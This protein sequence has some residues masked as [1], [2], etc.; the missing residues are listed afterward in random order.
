MPQLHAAYCIPE[1]LEHLPPSTAPI[2]R[3]LL[4]SLAH[5]ELESNR[6]LQD[7]G[8][9]QSDA[10]QT[11][12]LLAV[13]MNLISRGLPTRAPLALSDAVL[14]A[15]WPGTFDPHDDELRGVGFD[16]GAVSPAFVRLL[17][18]ALHVVEPRM[19]AEQFRA[20]TKKYGAVQLDSGAERTFLNDIVAGNVE[21]G[22]G[23]AQVMLPQ[24]PL[25][26]LLQ[27]GIDDNGDID[28][29]RRS[30][31][32]NPSF[33]QHVD[34]AMPLPYAWPDTGNAPRGLVM[35][36]DGPH[37]KEKGQRI[38]DAARDKAAHE[39]RWRTD[40]LPVEEMASPDAFLHNLLDLARNHPYCK[41]LR[42][43]CK[44][45]LHASD[46]GRRAEQL[47]LTPIL[48]ARIHRALLEALTHGILK[49]DEKT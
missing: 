36:V 21:M 29:P 44:Q 23:L 46:D 31:D 40:R 22:L 7:P 12:S 38:K 32:E 4:R 39:A 34:F 11:S 26:Q 37:H 3:E 8:V 1:M 28:S 25:D 5:F 47:F 42:L 16:L 30:N 35:E 20:I 45:P 14:R 9:A 48:A 6:R 43:N 15:A 33:A 19:T 24:V 18:R 49:L 27:F 17:M 2:A 41:T 10:D 13:A